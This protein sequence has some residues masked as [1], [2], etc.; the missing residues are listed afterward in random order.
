MRV[1][2]RYGVDLEDIPKEV[3]ALMT[4]A[5]NI[6]YATDRAFLECTT[7]LTKS[8]GEVNFFNV[9]GCVVEAREAL[10]KADML[11]SDSF[12]ILAGY[13]QARLNQAAGSPTE[14]E[15]EVPD[16]KEVQEG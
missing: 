1:Q 16:G 15:Q 13:Q 9:Q 7:E 6:L 10:A 8:E 11:L 4:K 5:Q 14:Q 3:A 2:I 12:A